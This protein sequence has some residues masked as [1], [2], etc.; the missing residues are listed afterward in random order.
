MVFSSMVFL[1]GFLPLVLII[2]YLCP[3]RLRNFFLF[4]ASL[5]FYAWGEPKYIVIML[6]STV[7]DYCNGRMM[8]YFDAREK[9]QYRKVILVLS[10]V[11]NIGILAFFK[12]TD[13]VLENISR[14]TGSGVKLL[15]LA[16]PI[17][18]S[19]YTFQTL[20]YT[21]DVYRRQVPIQKNIID[22]GMYV[23]LFPQLIAGPIVRYADLHDQIRN[24]KT[25]WGGRAE[26]LQRFLIGLGK[27]VLLANQ[28]GVLWDEISALQ[29]SDLSVASA[30]LG[31]LAFTFQIYFDFSG[32]SDM[33][34]G[35]GG[36]LGFRFPENFRYPYQSQSITEFWRRW[37]IT[38]GTWFREYV[39]IPL[40]GN[41]KGIIRQIFNLLLVW[42]LTG[43]WHG[44]GWN[45]ILWGLYFFVLL[46]V[47]KLILQKEMKRWPKWLRH[48]Y[49]LF[50][51]IL[52]WAIFANDDM[53]QLL[54]Y[55][56]AMFGAGVVLANDISAYY[57]YSYSLFLCILLVGSLEGPKKL[58]AGF[59]RRLA[60]RKKG[61]DGQ[62]AKMEEAG[63]AERITFCLKSIYA[64]LLLFVSLAF[65]ISGSYNPFLYF[66][67]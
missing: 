34:I 26:G 44:A 45:F 42:F 49:A 24:R 46:L 66:R 10:V 43:L 28:I 16:L 31:A 6:F 65:L 62:E 23:C 11:V 14:L 63:S 3:G 18:I 7:F 60:G 38:L 20:S 19:F 30:W 8:G 4:L 67:F 32:Y 51:I 35:L 47:E 50:F 13:F 36:M 37:H 53:A 64:L 41:R 40:G 57:W 29:L 15:E 1:C 27:K 17:G 58:A 9:L 54:R 56:K 12:Y 33:A 48:V 2:Y 25:D 55:I 59:C 52:G 5:F 61:K 22:F 39:Y 21:I